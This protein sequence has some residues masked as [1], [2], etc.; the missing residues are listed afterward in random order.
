M[1]QRYARILNAQFGNQLLPFPLKVPAYDAY[2]YWHVNAEAEPA[3]AWLRQQLAR[4]LQ[5]SA[6][7]ARRQRSGEMR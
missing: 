5:R 4:T 3:N 7:A 6:N 2:L 1:P